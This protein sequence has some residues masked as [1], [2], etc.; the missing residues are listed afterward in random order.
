MA[1][2]NVME[3]ARPG[4][5]ED[6][7]DDDMDETLAE[8]LWGLTEMFPEPVQKFV[9]SAA[10]LSFS[11]LLAG[12]SLG[13]SALWIAATSATI[14]VLPVIFESERAQQQEQQLQQQR[15]ILLGPNAAV[16]GSTG[17]NL[18]PG[19]GMMPHGMTPPK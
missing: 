2:E 15:Q 12:Y 4:F 6:D 11:A 3:I 17:S 9:G 5:H 10:R 8:R 16:S 14:M 18:L 19:M 7:N 13:R 1:G